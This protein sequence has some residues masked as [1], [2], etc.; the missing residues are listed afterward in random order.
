MIGQILLLS[1]T[2]VCP[3]TDFHCNTTGRCIP[4][5]W[6]CDGEDDCSDGSDESIEVDC[7]RGDTTLCP[8]NQFWC[9]NHHC[10]DEVC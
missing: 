3:N 1:E 10:I 9:A 2:R 8:P 6:T 7:P 5:S 4:L